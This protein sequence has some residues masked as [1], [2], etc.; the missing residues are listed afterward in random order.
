MGMRAHQLLNPWNQRNED[1]IIQMAREAHA[2]KFLKKRLAS[3]T[4]TTDSG[5][6]RAMHMKHLDLRMKK[7]QMIE[8]RKQVIATENRKLMEKMTD[9]V[10]GKG[11]SPLFTAP[12][13][14][15]CSLNQRER[16]EYVNRIN[17]DN[18]IMIERLRKTSGWLDVKKMEEDYQLWL[19]NRKIGSKAYKREKRAAALA[20]RREAFS[21]QPSSGMSVSTARNTGGIMEQQQQPKSNFY[22]T[23]NNFNMSTN[24]DESG[25]NNEYA[26]SFRTA[27]ELREQVA[28]D[29]NLPNVPTV[30]SL[31][32]DPDQTGPIPFLND[33]S[34]KPLST[35]EGEAIRFGLEHNP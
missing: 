23:S 20:R 17:L 2:Q 29:P 19:E 21:R 4:K 33:S 6:P 15:A 1:N 5:P 16:E 28:N 12:K 34:T 35:H 25:M 13:T 22:D 14:V 24:F 30:T 32:S 27:R 10:K 3:V 7:K 18:K 8:D 9:I 31:V 26:P 11:K